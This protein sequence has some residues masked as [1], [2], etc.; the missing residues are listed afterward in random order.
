MAADR[1]AWETNLDTGIDRMVSE[2]YA[3]MGATQSMY[4]RSGYTLLYKCRVKNKKWRS[5]MFKVAQDTKWG[6]LTEL[7]EVSDLA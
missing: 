6:S 4:L 1:W 5:L 7:P 3:F 2:D